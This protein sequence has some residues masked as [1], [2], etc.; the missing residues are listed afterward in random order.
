MLT[1]KKSLLQVISPRMIMVYLLGIISG[2][3]LAYTGTTL[4]A[5]LA[6]SKIDLFSIGLITLVGMPY[7]YKFIWAPLL[8]RYKPFVPFIS[9]K[10]KSWVFCFQIILAIILFIMSDLTPVEHIYFIAACGLLI[11]FVSAS[12]DI[13][14]DAYR[15]EYLLRDERGI[16]AASFT[17]AYRL[18]MLISGGAGLIIADYYSWK[19]FF[20]LSSLMMLVGAVVINFLP[21]TQES[22]DHPASFI[23]LFINPFKNFLARKYAVTILFFIASYKFAEGYILSLATA[24]FIN[25]IHLSLTQV[26]VLFKTVGFFS[27][28]FGAYLAGVLLPRLGLYRSLMLFGIYQALAVLLYVC[29]AIIGQGYVLTAITVGVE[30]AASGMST[31]ALMAYFMSLCDKKFTGTQFAIFTAIMVIGRIISG[32]MASVVVESFGWAWMFFLGVMISFP[33]L[34]LLKKLKPTIELNN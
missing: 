12:Q 5:W 20:I 22:H 26:G 6:S 9:H 25:G 17:F 14:I 2:L 8:D 3:P 7:S 33:G 34:V 29:L 18:G 21:N 16:A 11:A 19:S 1:L 30:M 28:I 24:F 31:V 32:P 10:R 15:T 13:V 23:T 27:T 4:Q